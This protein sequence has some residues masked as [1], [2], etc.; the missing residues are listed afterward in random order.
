M[1]LIA[2]DRA[3]ARGDAASLEAAAALYRGPLLE[4]CTEE[5]AFQ[6]RQVREQ[7]YLEALE[8]LAARTVTRGDPAEAASYLSR[9]AAVDPLRESAQR[10]LMQA[11]AAAGNYAAALLT[12]RELRLRLHRELNAE[13][14]PETQVLFQQLRAEARRLAA[15][16]SERQGLRVRGQGSAPR[17]CRRP[18]RLSRLPVREPETAATLRHNLPRPLT[19]TIGREPEIRTVLGLLADHPLVTLTGAGGCGKSR[20][21][22]RWRCRAPRMFPPTAQPMVYGSWNWRRSR[23]RRSSRRASRRRSACGRSRVSR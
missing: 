8:T 3:I 9:A 19:R 22:L 10:G 4:G 18:A 1:D 16:G 23:T 13:P 20:W 7:A 17:A 11:L 14:D 6:E 21:P 2:F 12:Y 15:K 5:W